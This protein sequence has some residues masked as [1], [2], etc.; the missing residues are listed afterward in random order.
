MFPARVAVLRRGSTCSIGFTGNTGV[1]LVYIGVFIGHGG[2]L[3]VI[4]EPM[5]LC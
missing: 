5:V 2:G 3:L 1:C 4:L